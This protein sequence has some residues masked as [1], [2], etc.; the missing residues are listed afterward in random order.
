MP[1]WMVRAIPACPFDRGAEVKAAG[2]SGL[3][4]PTEHAPQR[5]GRGGQGRAGPKEKGLRL[6]FL[7]RGILVWLVSC[8]MTEPSGPDSRPSSTGSSAKCASPSASTSP[9]PNADGAPG[10]G[11]QIE[12]NR[13]RLASR[14]GLRLRRLKRSIAALLSSMITMTTLIVSITVV[15]LTL[16]ASQFGSRLIRSFMTDL[17]KWCSGCSR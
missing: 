6:Q 2:G 1:K 12:R 5:F 7:P 10:L 17:T 11:S 14:A 16:A 15:V 3:A 8:R 13:D 4:I 9:R